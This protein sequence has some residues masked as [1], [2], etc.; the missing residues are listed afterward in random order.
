[1]LIPLPPFISCKP[2]NP[3]HVTHTHTCKAGESNFTCATPDMLFTAAIA[4]SICTQAVI[5]GAN[6]NPVCNG[7]SSLF[8]LRPGLYIFLSNYYRPV[9]LV[10]TWVYYIVIFFLLWKLAQSDNEYLWI[11]FQEVTSCRT[12]GWQRQ[13]GVCRGRPRAGSHCLGLSSV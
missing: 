8:T 1:M 11:C 9:L 13:C 7:S 3:R 4:M 5:S 10:S 6:S 12:V 2:A